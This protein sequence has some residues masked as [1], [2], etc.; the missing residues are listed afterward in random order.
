[1][2]LRCRQDCIEAPIQDSRS[3]APPFFCSA[4]CHFIGVTAA[5]RRHIILKPTA[6]WLA[7]AYAGSGAAAGCITWLA[8]T[9]RMPVFFVEGQGGTLLRSLMVCV[10]V[11]VFLLTA[12]LLWMI[13]RRLVSPFFRWYAQGLILTAIGLTGSLFITVGDSPLQWATMITHVFGLI[14]MC[15]AVQA[16]ALGKK[17][18]EKL[19]AAVWEELRENI[20]PESIRHLMSWW[21]ILRY[22]FVIAAVGLAIM[23]RQGITEWFGPGLPP[24]LTLYPAVMV[25]AVVAGFGPGMVS[26]VLAALLDS[27]VFPFADHF[28]LI[29]RLGLVIFTGMGFGISA[30]AELSRIH[31]RKAAEYDRNLLLHEAQSRLATFNMRKE[32]HLRQLNRTLRARTRGIEAMMHATEESTFLQE[33]CRIIVED[34]GHRMVWVGYAGNNAEKD[35]IPKAC[36]GFEDG[37][38]ETLH[39]TWSDTESGHGPTGT[40]IRTGR[41]GICRNIQTD[42]LPPLLRA[43][44]LKR[45]YASALALPLPTPEGQSLGAITIYSNYPDPFTEQEIKLLTEMADNFAYGILSLRLRLEKEKSEVHCENTRPCWTPRRDWRKSAAGITNIC[46]RISWSAEVYRIYGVSPKTFDPNNLELL[47]DFFIPGLGTDQEGIAGSGDYGN[48]LT[49]LQ[50]E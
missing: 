12:D 37:Y 2:R 4:L 25:V 33:I 29:D 19:L 36:S 34:C 35:V 9:G 28:T 48:S 15:V 43:E 5:L 30:L 39:L 42:P 8:L 6:L 31:R 27:P 22:G 18:E 46:R 49:T 14:Y 17:A 38:L 11:S 23:L 3:A 41:P 26:T 24:S 13:N 20:L 45:E 40:A 7:A 1:M 32:E 10:T 21:W 44:A 16:P 50:S 47:K